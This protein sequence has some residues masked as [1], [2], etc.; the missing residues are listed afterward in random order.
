MVKLNKKIQVKRRKNNRHAVPLA[1]SLA[2]RLAYQV[3]GLRGRNLI[4]S[5]PQYCKATIYNHCVKDFNGEPEKDKRT[6]NKGRPPILTERD[7]RLI[8]R[9]LKLSEIA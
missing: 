5:F 6:C 9:T 7:E 8:I 2:M 4:N 3:T 1:H